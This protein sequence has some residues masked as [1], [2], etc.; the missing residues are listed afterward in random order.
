[1]TTPLESARA[2]SARVPGAGRL[3]FAGIVPG[4][5]G[6]G[7][8][9]AFADFFTVRG[10]LTCRFRGFHS[11]PFPQALKERILKADETAAVPKEELSRLSM[12]LG[13]FYAW[14]LEQSLSLLNIRRED[15]AAAGC[16]GQTVGHFPARR[17]GFRKETGA[18]LQ[19]GEPSF[20]PLRTGI[21]AVSDFRPADMAAG[22]MGAPL[23]PAFHGILLRGRGCFTS[24][25]DLG[26]TG[27]M[28][29]ASPQGK[30]LAAYDTG[31]GNMLLDGAMRLL[32]GG[33]RGTDRDGAW[34]LRGKV[35]ETFLSR[36]VREDRFLRLPPPKS[37]GRERYGS[38]R[39]SRIMEAGRER[40]LSREDVAATLTA[41]TAEAVR[42]SF[43]RFVLP[44]WPV[45]EVFLGG[46]GARNPALAAE[47]ARRIPGLKV[48][49]TE[50]LGIGPQYVEAGAFAC[51]AYLAL[52]R[53][54]G[55]V[56]MATGGQPA[57]LGKISP[58]RR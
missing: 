24:F 10:N 36:L 1:M 20:I 9:V 2:V 5:S 13:D 48:R 52:T 39:L 17:Q 6:G 11:V 4:T 54:P 22:G 35:D 53:Q 18:T 16:H 49:S 7:V 29:V 41:Y 56:P 14:A 55:N 51:L 42:L 3:L 34:A 44:K 32:S 12:A 58:G 28:T 46:G 8:H 15:V 37:T 40:G 50:T 57:I 30:V 19:I 43:E 26:G 21:T 31:P 25:Q 38:E 47:I 45:K 27:S 33:R 23:A